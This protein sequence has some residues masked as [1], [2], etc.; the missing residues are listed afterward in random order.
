MDA[1][2]KS[3]TSKITNVSD[4]HMVADAIQRVNQTLSDMKTQPSP[5]GHQDPGNSQ[6]PAPQPNSGPAPNPSPDSLLTG[7][8]KISVK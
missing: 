1:L 3:M 2:L 8:G 5:A 6:N 4:M 7:G